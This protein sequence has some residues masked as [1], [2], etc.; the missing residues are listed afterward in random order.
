MVNWGG[1]ICKAPDIHFA[2][3]NRDFGLCT[4][5]DDF[6]IDFL[7]VQRGE[8]LQYTTMMNYKYLISGELKI[9]IKQT[10]TSGERWRARGGGK[11]KKNLLGHTLR[12]RERQADRHIFRKEDYQRRKRR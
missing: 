11:A 5:G 1:K 12:E 6:I 2:F 8:S 3:N 10:G 4:H 7:D 9:Y